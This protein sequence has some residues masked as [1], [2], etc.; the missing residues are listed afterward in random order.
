MDCKAS[1]PIEKRHE[2]LAGHGGKATQEF[3]DRIAS[4]DVVQEGLHGHASAWEHR[5]P[6]HNIWR[7]TDDS[8]KHGTYVNSPDWMTQ[9]PEEFT[10]RMRISA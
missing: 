3:V 9:Q 8:F 4:F 2:M 1:S 5:G 10:A 6:A 7:G